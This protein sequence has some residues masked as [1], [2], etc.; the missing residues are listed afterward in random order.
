MYLGQASTGNLLFHGEK[1]YNSLQL[2]SQTAAADVIA[3]GANIVV[4][5]GPRVVDNNDRILMY[6]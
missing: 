4:G 3:V 6:N 5:L 1:S 2:H